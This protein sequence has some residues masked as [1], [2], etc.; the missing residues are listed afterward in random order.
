[1]E[2]YRAKYRTAH[3]GQFDLFMPFFEEALNRLVEGGW[4]GWSVSSTFLR[5]PSGLRVVM[6]LRGTLKL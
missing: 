3:S 4:L 6:P 5:T 1:V 2:R